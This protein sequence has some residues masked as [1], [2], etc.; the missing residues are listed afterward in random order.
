VIDNEGIV[1]CPDCKGEG[2]IERNG[3]VIP[4]PTC[5]GTGLIIKSDKMKNENVIGVALTKEACP[6]CGAVQDG[7]II[8]NTRLSPGNA[9]KV[10]ALHGQVVGYMKKP[11]EECQGIM[12]QGI[13]LIGVVEAKTDDHNNPY[14]SG[15]KWGVTEDFINRVFDPEMAKEV[16]SKRACFFPVE[17]AVQMGFPKVNI[18]A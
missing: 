12:K 11:C 17:V 14:R 2:L 3:E 15:N 5:K 10:E 8:I 18:D 4:C 7:D 13:L 1:N 9:K 16:I 6:L